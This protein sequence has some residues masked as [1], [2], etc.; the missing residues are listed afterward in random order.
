MNS[1]EIITLN[2]AALAGFVIGTF[3]FGGLWWTVRYA[4]RGKRPALLFMI[5]LFVRFGLALTGFYFIGSGH[6]D[7]L[8]ACLLGFLVS[9][10]LIGRF[11]RAS[12]RR[13]VRKVANALD[14]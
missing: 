9:R 8:I 13:T 1:T 6:P 2:F 7:R 11:L 14:S 3:F 10:V 12:G 5:S 4:I